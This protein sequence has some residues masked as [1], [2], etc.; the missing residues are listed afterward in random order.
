MSDHNE[1]EET[2]NNN[3]FVPSDGEEQK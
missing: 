2:E 3:E 1:E